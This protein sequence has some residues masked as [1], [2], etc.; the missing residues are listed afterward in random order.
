[1]ALEG[2]NKLKARIDDLCRTLSQFKSK[3]EVFIGSAF[4]KMTEDITIL[5]SASAKNEQEKQD[6]I[7]MGKRKELE[8]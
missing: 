2:L 7:F 8:Q 3:S 5:L 6:L 4:V 1:M